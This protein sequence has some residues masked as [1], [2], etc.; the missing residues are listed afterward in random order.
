[1]LLIESRQLRYLSRGHDYIYTPLRATMDFKD[2][3][4]EASGTPEVEEVQPDNDDERDPT[5]HGGL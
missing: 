4:I 1:M 2:V 3:W 5:R